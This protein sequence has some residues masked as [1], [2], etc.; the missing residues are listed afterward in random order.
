MMNSV[1][2]PSIVVLTLAIATA[3]VPA[4]DERMVVPA[5]EAAL[6]A[7]LAG[8]DREWNFSFSTGG[9]IRVL[10]AADLAYF[11]RYRDAESGPQIVLADGGVVRADLLRADLERFVIGDATGLAIGQWDESVLPRTAVRGLFWQPPAAP[12][13]RDRLLRDLTQYSEADD[14]LLLID[15][16]SISGKVVGLPQAAANRPADDRRDVEAFRLA[17]EGATEPLVVPAAKVVAV[18]FGGV[19]T[20]GLDDAR[21][22]AWIGLNDGSLVH[23]TSVVVRGDVVTVSLAAGGQLKSTT[24][25]RGGRA[26][27]FWDAVTYIELRGPRVHWIS[28]LPHAG[29]KHIPYI[30]VQRQPAM[31]Q[32]VLGSRLRHGETV[33]RK[34][35]GMPSA[36]RLAYDVAGFRR[37]EAEIAIDEQAALQGSAVFKVLLETSPGQWQAAY[38]S[39]VVRGGDPPR[40]VSVDLRGA[41]RLA[42]IVEFADRGDECDYANWLHARLIK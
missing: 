19:P 33:V 35:V 26:K 1:R 9:R 37:F 28:D 3:P 32:S 16:Q 6:P 34:G 21:I 12:A 20:E 27:S 30:S 42:L 10:A 38:E 7:V 17:R 40:R 22:S 15:G 31:D 18:S 11:G 41:A 13:D 24:S 4:Q 36:S 29:Y 25:G 2:V 23:G 39:P 8:I 5:N 14:R